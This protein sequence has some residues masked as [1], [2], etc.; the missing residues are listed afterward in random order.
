[1]REERRKEKDS[2]A[3][4]DNMA[5]VGRAFHQKEQIIEAD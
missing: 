2:P 3:K 4:D 1:M 5:D